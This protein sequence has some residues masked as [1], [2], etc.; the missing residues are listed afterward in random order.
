MDNSGS[1]VEWLLAHPGILPKSQASYRCTPEEKE[2]RRPE[3][4]A[5]KYLDNNF[6]RTNS[7]KAALTPE[8]QQFP[9][10]GRC[11]QVQG[12]KFILKNVS[13]YAQ[14]LFREYV[15][16]ISTA[17]FVWLRPVGRPEFVH[18][19]CHDVAVVELFEKD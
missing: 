13:N 14:I 10:N 5:Y 17:S 4:V 8:F 9:Q 11:R 15:K 19:V 2:R 18:R 12:I 1:T 3:Q 6:F 7:L 16:L